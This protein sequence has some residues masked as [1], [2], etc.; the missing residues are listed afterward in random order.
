VAETS[1]AWALR[2]EDGRLLELDVARW[3]A[4]ADPVDQSLL[5]RAVGPVLDVGCGPGRHVRALRHRGVPALGVDISSSAVSVA[6]ERGARVLQRSVFDA[7]P[8]PGR[9]R[10]ALLLDGS[11]G[12][13]GDPV[14]LLRRIGQLLHRRGRVLVEVEPPEVATESMV[15]RMETGRR[16]SPWFAWARVS[17]RDAAAVAHD[18]GFCVAEAWSDG[19]RFFCRLDRSGQPRLAAG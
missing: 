9:W 13:G 5:D 16:P 14:V 19:G 15:V 4:P 18:A 12:I 17:A 2:A 3:L 8:D 11:V 7:L 1:A 10:S 6:R